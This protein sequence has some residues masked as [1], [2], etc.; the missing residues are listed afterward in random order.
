MSGLRECDYLE[1]ASNFTLGS[2]SCRCCRKKLIFGSFVE[3]MLTLPID[4]V[5]LAG[6]NTN[7][8]KTKH[9]ILDTMKDHL[10]PHITEKKSAKEMY[11]VLTTVYKIV[12]MSCKILLKIKLSTTCISGIDTVFTS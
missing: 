3:S 6:H 10:I 5:Q 7:M 4:F 1:D 2:A 12:N 8:V 11:D 9:F